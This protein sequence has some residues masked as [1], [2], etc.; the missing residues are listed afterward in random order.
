MITTIGVYKTRA[1]ADAAIVELKD[2][3]V[4]GSEISYLHLD[5]DGDVKDEQSANK[6][7]KGAV[8]G[9]ATGAVL[10]AIA[11]LV[12]AN[13]VLPG[14]GTFFVAGPLAAALGLGGAAATTVAGAATGAAAGGLI[15][16]LASL[17]VDKEDATLYEEMIRRGDILVV[18]RADVD[19]KAV[20]LKTNASELRQYRT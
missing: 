1:E 18:V 9:A 12:V 10:G 15:G 11:G 16:A 20:F 7:G 2:F 17:G 5:K 19:P 13:G 8:A 4:S 14:L 3:G 6:V